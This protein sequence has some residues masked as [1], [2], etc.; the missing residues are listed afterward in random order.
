MK[1]FSK[2]LIAASALTLPVPA[3]AASFSCTGNINLIGQWDQGDVMVGTQL[4]TFWLCNVT[5]TSTT[6][7]GISP[8]TCKGWLTDLLT[9]R[10]LNRS[11]TFH[12]DTSHTNNA[13]MTA[14]YCQSSNFTTAVRRPHYIEIN[15]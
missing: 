14:P 1:I 9:A 4:G 11:V 7:S 8:E 12:F 13:T 6:F 3:A 2:I 10:G 15:L 5:T